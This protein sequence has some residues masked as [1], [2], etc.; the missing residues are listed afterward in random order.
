MFA[1]RAR[2]GSSG[3]FWRWGQ[4][5]GATTE[6]GGRR[7]QRRREVLLLA[8]IVATTMTARLAQ[9]LDQ[10]WRSFAPIIVATLTSFLL[11]LGAALTL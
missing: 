5:A 4:F 6:G 2:L 7:R 9:L 1:K 3:A 8:A 11:S 10:G